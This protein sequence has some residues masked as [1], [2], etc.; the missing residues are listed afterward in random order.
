MEIMIWLP[1]GI[2]LAIACFL[3]FGYAFARGVAV[4]ADQRRGLSR[5]IAGFS[6]V[7][8]LAMKRISTE[9]VFY[10]LLF[11]LPVISVFLP[12]MIIA[13][14]ESIQLVFD[15]WY[16]FIALVVFAFAFPL[17]MK[18]TGEEKDEF[19]FEDSRIHNNN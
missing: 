11:V 18:P 17:C 13:P 3:F 10:L 2:A 5:E 7:Y 6:K 19:E 8:V 9:I 14:E 15:N 1:I 4:I 16:A 12:G